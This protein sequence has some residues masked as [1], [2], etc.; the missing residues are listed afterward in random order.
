MMR[1]HRKLLLAGLLLSLAAMPRG[2]A[3]QGQVYEPQP[4]R[5]SA[6]V[7]VV[8]TLPAEVTIRPDFM[9]QQRLGTEPERRV[10]AY[11][12]VENVAGRTLHLEVIEG[13]QRG[14]AGFQ[15]EPGSFVT[16][17]LHRNAHGA[18]AAVAIADQ[19]DFNR[20][21]ARLAFY[22]SL[23]DCPAAALQLLP[24]GQAVFGDV[25]ALTTKSRTVNPVTADVRA[26]CGGQAA[27]PLSLKD[28]EAG[29]MYS[30][31]LIPGSRGEAPHQAFLTRDVTAP[32]RR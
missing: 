12:V 13:G 17:L 18:P 22:N 24:G 25:P 23:P 6:Y 8:N 14:Q 31:W 30:I 2:A 1:R 5:G 7:R 32:W 3:A 16:V 29:G 10:M 20:A 15:V 21:R 26:V 19:A 28:L 4:P 9:T 27:P 11:T